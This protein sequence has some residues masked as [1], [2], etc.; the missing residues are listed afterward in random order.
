MPKPLT[1]GQPYRTV[2]WRWRRRRLRP[3]IISLLFRLPLLERLLRNMWYG[4]RVFRYKW[5]KLYD[6]EK[7]YWIEPEKIKYTSL[8]WFRV[9][10]DNGKI[11]R[12]GWDRLEQRFEDL[13][14]YLA[15]KER[16]VEGGNWENTLFY[17]RILSEI[18]DG[19]VRWGCRNNPDL[20]RRFENLDALFQNIK[21]HG[22][23]TQGEILS[24]GNIYNP[25][26]LKDEITVNVGR[27]G[28]LLFNNGGHR[29]AI[30][31]LLGIKKIPVKITVRHPEWVN[32]TRRVWLYAKSQKGGKLYQP[33]THP[34]LQ[35]IPSLH[36][37]YDRF[38]LIR[39]NLSVTKGR[40]LDIGAHWGYFCHKFEEMGFDCYAVENDEP[41]VYF[42]RKLKRA[43]NRHFEL[44]PKSI[45]EY[46]DIGN[47]CFDVVLALNIFHHFL[48]QKDYYLELI[49]LLK[50]L[51][52]KEMFFQ[53]HRAD[54]Q[55]MI[56][57]YMNYNEEEFV[58]FILKTSKLIEAQLLGTVQG[59]RNIYKLY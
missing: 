15:F 54:E 31:K 58:D 53:P 41:N 32:F 51:K 29:L 2:D 59:G 19:K 23:K 39:N 9:Y 14:L 55:Q 20:D 12:G 35:N 57:A 7:I 3:V 28:D 8:R 4:M 46:E 44:I 48:K 21:H 43:E 22:Y 11:I 45:F 26:Q 10:L 34:D 52:M 49:N 6:A 30:A 13:D 42:L 18:R 27:N 47:L 17:R 50:N 1:R 24:E 25:M 16:F 5:S 56:D 37:S 38:N 36:D 33:I 40:L